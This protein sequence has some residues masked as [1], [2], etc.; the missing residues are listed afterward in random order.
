MTT[1]Q[2]LRIE[3]ASR[4]PKES[5]SFGR[6]VAWLRP[7]ASFQQIPPDAALSITGRTTKR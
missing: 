1:T 5:K 4:A 7:A 3:H 2:H 6:G